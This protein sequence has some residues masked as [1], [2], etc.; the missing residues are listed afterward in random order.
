MFHTLVY[1]N[2][3]ELIESSL[4]NRLIRQSSCID[5]ICLMLHSFFFYDKR[6]TCIMA[7][8]NIIMETF[9]Q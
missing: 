7:K 4:I 3:I 8:F 9:V 2:V 5:F 6:Q 1:D